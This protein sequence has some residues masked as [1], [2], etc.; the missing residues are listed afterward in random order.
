MGTASQFV[1]VFYISTALIKGAG[2]SAENL[3]GYVV[4]SFLYKS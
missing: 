1:D 2:A 3:S 4:W